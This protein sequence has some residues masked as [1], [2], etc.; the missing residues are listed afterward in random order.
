MFQGKMIILSGATDKI[1]EGCLIG[2]A[3][4]GIYRPTFDG[5]LSNMQV[6]GE[7]DFERAR[8]VDVFAAAP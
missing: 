1:S 2:T 7:A 4:P 5:A 6:M 3:V 8:K